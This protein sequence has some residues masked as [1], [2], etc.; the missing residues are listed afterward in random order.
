MLNR[1]SEFILSIKDG[2]F[3]KVK[4]R[5]NAAIILSSFLKDQIKNNS[6]DNVLILGIP[7]GGVIMAETMSN[8]LHIPFDIILA[9][10]LRAPYDKEMAIGAIMEDGYVY[11]NNNIINS[12]NIS[13]N[14]LEKEKINRIEEIS[15]KNKLYQPY[16]SFI[17]FCEKKNIINKIISNKIII[18]VD[19]GAASGATLMVLLNWLKEKNPKKII[20][21]ITVAPKETIKLLKKEA[22]DIETILAPSHNFK[23]VSQYYK[24]F[25][26]IT[27]EQV[28]KILKEKKW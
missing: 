4:D 9:R 20:V 26:Q 8:E 12:L 7:R 13:K 28:L 25:P 18:I 10:K 23:N 24:D 22:K 17:N 14:Y 11:L 1:L 3:I 27:D 6:S 19:D 15:S 16:S 2:S 21:A 5:Y